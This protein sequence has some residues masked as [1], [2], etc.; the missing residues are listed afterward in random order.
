M[1]IVSDLVDR[2]IAAGTP[3]EVAASVVTEAYVAGVNSSGNST[4]SRLDRIREK[5]RE[6]KRNA[7][8][9]D[10]IPLE[11][12]GIHGTASTSKNI[13]TKSGTTKHHLPLEWKPSEEHFAVAA[14]LNIPKAA[15]EAKASDLRLWA[16]SSGEKKAD[17]DA[18]FESFLRKDA[19]KLAAV[20]TKSAETITPTSPSWNAWKSHFRDAGKNFQAGL[21][22]KAA[23]EG[24]PFTVAS[25]WPPG[26]DPPQ[27][28]Q[29]VSRENISA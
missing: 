26:A 13:N 22:D 21:M 19:A 28:Y 6:R 9:S 1:T 5:D 4:D 7:K 12:N 18:T 10:G 23:N 16:K 29:H 25:E 15:V 11:S 3:P 27:P 20:E 17:W 14:E 24:K 2:L 8:H